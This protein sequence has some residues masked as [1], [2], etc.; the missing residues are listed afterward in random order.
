MT[1]AV[2]PA[3]PGVARL[4]LSQRLTQYLGWVVAP[5][6]GT[7]EAL[8]GDGTLGG[9]GTLLSTAAFTGRSPAGPALVNTDTAAGGCAWPYPRQLLAGRDPTG[10]GK[11]ATCAVYAAVTSYASFG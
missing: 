4:D 8:L 10:N 5:G 3:R 9:Q 11:S 1:L 7:T 6:L 2:A